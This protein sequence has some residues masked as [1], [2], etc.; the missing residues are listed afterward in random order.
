MAKKK[1][2]VELGEKLTAELD[3]IIKDNGGSR[4]TVMICA[5]KLFLS[6]TN[7][8]FKNSKEN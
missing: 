2:F 7:Q 3:Q 8:T 1:V 5:L 4:V 6:Q